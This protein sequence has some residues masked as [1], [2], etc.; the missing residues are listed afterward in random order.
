MTL[1]KIVCT[2]GVCFL[3]KFSGVWPIQEKINSMSWCT[4]CSLVKYT[5]Q[6][7]PAL[8]VYFISDKIVLKCVKIHDSRI[9]ILQLR[10]SSEP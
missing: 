2:A 6:L 1:N 9:V 7:N 4:M 3:L 10:R 8:H 5:V